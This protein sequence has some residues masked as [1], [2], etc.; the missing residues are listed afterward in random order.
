PLAQLYFALGI[1][2]VGEETAAILA[3]QFNGIDKLAAAGAEELM[4]IPSIGPKIS[5]GILAFFR[6]PQ[7]VRII[8][9]LRKAGVVMQAAEQPVGEQPLSGMEFVITGKLEMSGRQEIEARIRSLGGKAASDVTRRTNYVVAGSDPG[10]KLA[11]AQSL[12]IKILTEKEFLALL[13]SHGG[14][15]TNQAKLL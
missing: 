12:G 6:Q 10:S 8:E 13:D 3:R 11:R 4:N 9:K 5:D 14:G 15:E 1:P 2:N 7:N